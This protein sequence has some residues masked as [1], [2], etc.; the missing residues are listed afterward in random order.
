MLLLIISNSYIKMEQPGNAGIAFEQ[1]DIPYLRSINDIC[2]RENNMAEVSINTTQ[3]T[4]DSV[5]CEYICLIWKNFL[6]L[7]S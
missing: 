7:T 5:D 3:N 4:Q 2:A 6:L 1:S